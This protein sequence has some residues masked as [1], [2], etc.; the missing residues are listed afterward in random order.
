MAGEINF[1]GF[2][3]F[4]FNQIIDVTIEAESAPLK[5]LEAKDSDLRKQDSALGSFGVEVA[6]LQDPVGD[7][8]LGTVFTDLDAASTDKDVAT[9]TLGDTAVSGTY[10]L[11]ITQ[12]AKAQVTASTNGYT[13]ATDT[14]TDGGT[15]SF[16]I[17]GST[18]TDITISAST[19][20]SALKTLINDQNSGVVASIVN[21]GTNNKLVISSRVMGATNGFTIN[22]S[23]TN[24]VSTVVAFAVGQSPTVGN[25]QD[26]RDSSFTVNG[27][28]ITSATNTVT[29]A[30]PG[31]TV[32]LV[33]AGTASVNVTPD[34]DTLKEHVKTF[35]TEYNSLK[36]FFV[37]QTQIDSITGKPGPLGNDTILRQALSDVKNLVLT[38]NGN[39]GQ[40]SYLT[41]IGVEF[42]IDGT[43]SLNEEQFNTA[44][45]TAVADVQKLFQG[46]GTVEGVFDDL[47]SAL[48]NIDSTA[49]L[50][51][52]TRDS[53]DT[54]IKSI[55]DQILAQQLR[56]ELRRTELQ[57]MYTAAD[58]AMSRITSQQGALGSIGAAF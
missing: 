57:K 46:D 10:D 8:V 27:L 11:V 24:G 51:K 54:T 6:D 45:D 7:L 4:D 15:I 44:I 14:A 33:K 52:T 50:I 22:N 5:A 48:A 58:L 12:L 23:L 19:S 29:D 53:L 55:R 41:E 17:G 25:S 37:E 3:G 21:D 1:S 43:L 28:A 2:N 38:S 18:T 26:A 47:K 31:T 32:T 36:E 39:D 56:L 13:N 9:V 42:E 35:I 30:V 34:Y 20:L 49:G 40:Y 16:T